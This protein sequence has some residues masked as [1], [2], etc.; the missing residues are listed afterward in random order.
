MSQR[1]Y[2]WFFSTPSVDYLSLELLST[3]LQ[4]KCCYIRKTKKLFHTETTQQ[5]LHGL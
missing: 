5:F 1:G 3:D 4:E 2:L